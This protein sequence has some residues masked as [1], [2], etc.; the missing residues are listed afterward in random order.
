[1]PVVN[2]DMKQLIDSIFN[3]DFKSL[4]RAIT[5]V[6]NE[7]NGYEE[8]LMNLQPK[9][10]PVIGTTGPPGAGKSSLINSLVKLLIGRQ[11]R[12]AVIAVDPT[13]PFNY[14]SLLGDRV[15]MPELFNLPNV[16]IRSLATRGSL[17]GLTEKI[18]EVTDVLKSA[19]FDFIFVETVG[20]GQS[21]VEI[22][23]LADVTM[24][25]FVPE[26]GDEIQTMK[27][28]VMEIADIFIVNKSDHAGAD[29]FAENLRK[30]IGEGHSTLPVLKTSAINNQGV[31]AI[32][33]EI[34]KLISSTKINEK[35]IY[36]LTEKAFRLIQ[37]ERMNDLNKQKLM[38]E[39]RQEVDKKNFSIYR[40]I[41]FYK[42][43][44]ETL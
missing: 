17:G 11:M 8:L 35:K 23:G 10:T 15:R 31:E 7:I 19:P 9:Q 3:G 24:V 13:S 41:K 40:F 29:S 37:R 27:S 42:G 44:N 6:E 25:V 36:L 4:A 16:F 14:G 34:E 38:Y 39:L 1:L 12:V 33:N 18:I 32:V 20:V 22:A 30:R 28:G 21:E 2:T 5:I 26:S 43:F